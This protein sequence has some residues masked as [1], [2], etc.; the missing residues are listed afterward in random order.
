MKIEL[1]EDDL[2]MVQSALRMQ[3]V[4]A[5]DVARSLERDLAWEQ[6]Y[7]DPDAA[8]GIR[9]RMDLAAETGDMYYALY[10]RLAAA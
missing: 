3:Y 9:E 1:S 4:S 7:G 2:L 10:Q 5:R 6:A 8:G